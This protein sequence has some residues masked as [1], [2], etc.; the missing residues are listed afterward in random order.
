MMVGNV[1]ALYHG[2]IQLSQASYAHSS[3]TVSLNLIEFYKTWVRV[4]FD[5][6]NCTTAVCDRA[7]AM[8]ACS[9]T[10]LVGT[11]N[12]TIFHPTQNC[13]AVKHLYQSTTPYFCYTLY[14]CDIHVHAY[15]SARRTTLLSMCRFVAVLTLHL[16]E[17]VRVC[18]CVHAYIVQ[19]PWFTVVGQQ[20]QL[21]NAGPVDNNNNNNNNGNIVRVN[22]N[23]EIEGSH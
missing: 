16:C 1:L 17:C 2:S 15:T 19:L 14:I 21:P 12:Y 7:L 22:D 5:K 4:L 3:N 6:L 20:G 18:V 10:V 23:V 8:Y 11:L 13:F 9:I